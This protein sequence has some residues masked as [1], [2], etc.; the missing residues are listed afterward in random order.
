MS[1]SEGASS[2]AWQPRWK[3]R[4]PLSSAETTSATSKSQTALRSTTRTCQC[5][6]PHF[7]D[8]PMGDTVTVGECWPWERPCTSTCSQS[9]RLVAPRSNS[10]SSETRYLPTPPQKIVIFSVMGHA[11]G[12]CDLTWGR[13]CPWEL[14]RINEK[15]GVL[16][17][18]WGIRIRMG[19]KSCLL[20]SHLWVKATC[21]KDAAP[22]KEK[23]QTL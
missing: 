15:D 22:L 4:G 18:A 2:L 14:S 9:P 1:S 20:P 10:R 11:P 17:H 16:F 3:C 7:R 12:V 23:S 5:T 8:V 19:A 21:I 13:Y 6:C